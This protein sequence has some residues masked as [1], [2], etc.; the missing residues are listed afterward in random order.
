LSRYAP[1]I[2]AAA[3]QSDDVP[4]QAEL[5]DWQYEFPTSSGDVE[6]QDSERSARFILPALI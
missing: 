3:K 6:L 5:D 1:A 4:Q 2:R